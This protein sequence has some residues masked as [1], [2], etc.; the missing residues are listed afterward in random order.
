M[1]EK[2]KPEFT[3][4][5]DNTGKDIVA[6][7][8]GGAKAVGAVVVAGLAVGLGLGAMDAASG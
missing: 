4:W 6:S 8:W 5:G 7:A 2:T 1:T 3:L